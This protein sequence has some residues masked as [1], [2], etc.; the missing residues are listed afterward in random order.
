MDMETI[1]MM[2]TLTHETAITERE[3]EKKM[4]EVFAVN[5]KL[6]LKILLYFIWHLVFILLRLCAS[7]VWSARLLLDVRGVQ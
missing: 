3:R 4:L 2:V 6:I 7:S 5:K 1:T